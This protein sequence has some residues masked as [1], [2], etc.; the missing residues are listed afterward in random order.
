MKIFVTGATGKIGKKITRLLVEN[1]YSVVALYRDKKRIFLKDKIEWVKG[2]LLDLPKKA[3]EWLKECDLIVHMA[4][5]LGMFDRDCLRVNVEG[6]KKLLLSIDG[7]KRIRFIYFSSIDAFGTTG[8]KQVNEKDTA[9]PYC[10][11]GKSKLLAEKAIVNYRKKHKSFSYVI[12]RLGNVAG[13]GGEDLL[14]CLYSIKKKNFLLKKI[15]IGLFGENEL[16]IV[17]INDIKR[18]FLQVIKK[19]KYKN[20]VRF[21]TG[22]NVSLLMLV[23]GSSGSFLFKC[24]KIVLLC[25]MKVS[26]RGGFYYYLGAGGVL[27][28][29]R[30]YSNKIYEELKVKLKNECINNN[31]NL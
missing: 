31:S 4:G 14:S 30:R 29:Y 2:D 10:V 6:T 21:L 20:R 5:K 22:K 12:L 7:G 24:F 19:K 16:N 13:F 26:R 15:L 25:L 3:S 23:S 27:R 18:V 11:Y 9:L 1:R 28:P 8:K 17:C